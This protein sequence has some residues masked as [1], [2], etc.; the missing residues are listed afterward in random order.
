[1]P[2]VLY[3]CETVFDN[4]VVRRIS[5]PK[6]DEIIGGWEKNCMR[7]SELVLFVKYN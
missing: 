3:G 2:V 4:G 6:R 5:G 1:L 7:S